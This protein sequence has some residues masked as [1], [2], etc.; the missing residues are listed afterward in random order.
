M[1]GYI[2]R[3]QWHQV[4]L[5]AINIVWESFFSFND[6][7]VPFQQGLIDSTTSPSLDIQFTWTGWARRMDQI[8]WELELWWGG[9]GHAFRK[10]DTCVG[11]NTKV[12]GPC[13]QVTTRDGVSIGMQIVPGSTE[14]VCL[15]RQWICGG[16]GCRGRKRTCLSTPQMWPLCDGVNWL[17]YSDLGSVFISILEAKKKKQNLMY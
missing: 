10:L 11:G 1:K 6:R 12:D 2:P 14:W 7:T 5:A 8:M 9:W 15:N 17:F 3:Y 4:L 13:Y 16:E